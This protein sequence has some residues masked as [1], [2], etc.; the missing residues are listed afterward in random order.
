MLRLPDITLP[1]CVEYKEPVKLVIQAGGMD[2][3]VS[4]SSTG[5]G[6]FSDGTEGVPRPSSYGSGD[7]TAPRQPSAIYFPHASSR[8]AAVRKPFSS[9]RQSTSTRQS[10]MND[11]NIE[12]S[13]AVIF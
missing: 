10:E 8:L 9:S 5:L 4:G 2:R 12:T 11:S 7:N 3:A 1:V 13:E 6:G